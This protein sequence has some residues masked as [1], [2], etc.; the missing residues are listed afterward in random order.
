MN[1][2]NSSGHSDMSCAWS[3]PRVVSRHENER[4]TKP[5]TVHTKVSHTL[6]G[7]WLDLER[8]LIS[9]VIRME[10]NVCNLTHSESSQ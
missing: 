8:V 2:V 4:H 3:G 10:V 9:K 5:N 1:V 6:A 7:K